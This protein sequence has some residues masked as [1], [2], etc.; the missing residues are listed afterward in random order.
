MRTTVRLPEDLLAQDRDYS[1][2][3]ELP[4]RHTFNWQVLQKDEARALHLPAREWLPLENEKKVHH[5]SF[6]TDYGELRGSKK[7]Q[8]HETAWQK[9][10]RP[11]E[12]IGR[13]ILTLVFLLV[14]A[15]V[16]AL[17]DKILKFARIGYPEA[18]SEGQR[19]A[20]RQMEGY[21]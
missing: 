21:N 16:T 11:H 18:R 14:L 5:G 2:F 3:P 9:A 17:Q 12:A 10:W 6:A 15:P 20:A 7:V 19:V 13:P 1:Y 8:Q 4:W